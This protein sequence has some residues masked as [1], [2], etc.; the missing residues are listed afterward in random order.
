[1]GATGCA[2]AARLGSRF[3]GDLGRWLVRRACGRFDRALQLVAD[4]LDR[5]EAAFMDRRH[6]IVHALQLLLHVVELGLAHGLVEL[7]L[8]L[9]RHAADLAVML[10]TVRKAFGRSFGPMTINATAPI[11]I[12]SPQLMSNMKR[13][14]PCR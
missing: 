2:F 4:G 14:R 5:V 12:T 6:G 10:P 3:A 7:T 11:T 13:S 1:M 8:K 9:R